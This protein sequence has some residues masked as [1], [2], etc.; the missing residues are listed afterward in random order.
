MSLIHFH[1]FLIGTA[2]LFCGGYAAREFAA[3]FRGAG[4]GAFVL[5]AVF[6]VL[7]AGLLVYLVHLRRFLGYD[8]GEISAR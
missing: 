2:I 7:G 4:M 6:A 1:R 5:G 8:E 3:A